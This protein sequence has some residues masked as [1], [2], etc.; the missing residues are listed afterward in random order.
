M[1][2]DDCGA[3]AWEKQLFLCTGDAG[4]GAFLAI[5]C[6]VCEHRRY[7]RGA[8]ERRRRARAALTAAPNVIDELDPE[9]QVPF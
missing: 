4:N 8:L 6:E 9:G 7:Y 1:N 5:L 2:C 3:A